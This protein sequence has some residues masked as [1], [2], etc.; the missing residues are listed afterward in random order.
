VN[1]QNIDNIKINY[2]IKFKII[3]AYY[4]SKLEL[5]SNLSKNFARELQVYL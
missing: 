5:K 2:S 3:E 1:T 4:N